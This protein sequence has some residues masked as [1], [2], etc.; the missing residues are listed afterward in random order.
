MQQRSVVRAASS[1]EIKRR[2][3][4]AIS[5]T[6]A[7]PLRVDLQFTYLLTYLLTTLSISA[8]AAA[9][10]GSALRDNTI[11]WR[12]GVVVSGVRQ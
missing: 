1:C 2:V 5:H 6:A 8:G 7:S 4:K 11:G 9:C 12:R 3:T 10:C